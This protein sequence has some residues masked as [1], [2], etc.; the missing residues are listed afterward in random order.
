MRKM[1]VRETDFISQEPRVKPRSIGAG[2]KSTAASHTDEPL[3]LGCGGR[4]ETRVWKSP[5]RGVGSLATLA[6]CGEATQ[7]L[8]PS[9]LQKCFAW[10]HWEE[11]AQGKCSAL[12]GGVPG[13]HVS[14]SG[15]TESQQLAGS[16]APSLFRIVHSWEECHEMTRRT[17]ILSPPVRGSL[18]N[19]G[20][21]KGQRQDNSS[22]LW[23]ALQWARNLVNII[24]NP[25]KLS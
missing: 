18:V 4:R 9:L 21:S 22:Y 1:R 6:A 20:Y 2:F 11:D 8:V 16:P 14:P 7:T 24:F 25:Q 10:G 13:L 3:R 12:P 23:G 17:E 5:T 19:G 15:A